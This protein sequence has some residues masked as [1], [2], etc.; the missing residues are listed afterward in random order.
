MSKRSIFSVLIVDRKSWKQRKYQLLIHNLC[1]AKTFW[2]KKKNQK[3]R[4]AI[5]RLSILF[6]VLLSSTFDSWLLTTSISDSMLLTSLC[7]ESSDPISSDAGN[8][9]CCSFCW[10][11]RSGG[12]VLTIFSRGGVTM[13]TS[14]GCETFP[15]SCFT[16]ASGEFPRFTLNG[17]LGILFCSP[18]CS[19]DSASVKWKDQ[20][21]LQCY[22]NWETEYRT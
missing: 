1:G 4:D 10:T 6:Q 22:L 20:L 18:F 12:S 3:N 2:N 16:G 9:L 5:F 19:A 15:T 17:G 8:S 21:F 7:C 13:C 11:A 14:E